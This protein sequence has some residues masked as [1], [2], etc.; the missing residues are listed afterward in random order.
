[1][2]GTGHQLLTTTTRTTVTV[3]FR[4]S[5]FT[6]YITLEEVT[7]AYFKCRKGKRNTLS[8]LK[9]EINYE[10]NNYQIYLDLNNKTY[11]ISPSIAFCTTKPL[12]REIFAANFRDRIVYTLFI[13][14]LIPTIEKHLIDNTFSCRKGKGPLCGIKQVS[15]M[16]KQAGEEA[17]YWKGDIQGF[18]MSIVPE[19]MWELVQEII[20]E[21]CPNNTDWWLWLGKIIIFNRPEQ[22]CIRAGDLKLWEKLPDR[23]SLFKSNGKGLPIGDLPS[24]V[25]SNLYLDGLDRF[26]QERLGKNEYYARGADDF[27]VIMQDKEKLLQLKND[28]K[29]WL[30]KNRKLI[31]HPKKNQ[32]QQV[33]RGVKFL[34][35]YIKGNR[36]YPSKRTI[37]GAKYIIK[38]FNSSKNKDLK[39][40]R[41]RLNSYFGLLRPYDSYNI[42]RKL[43]KLIKDY[44]H[45]LNINNKKIKII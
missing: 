32:I 39:R 38:E 25:L 23:K 41:N 17:W 18:F 42:R 19:I 40:F 3:L 15:K 28:V 22:N 36:I 2:R 29:I 45:L 16:M 9:Y 24:S 5:H 12:L 30:L 35:A 31:L 37:Y 33:K 8:A 11:T 6:M 34:G 20:K 10:L 43:W 21:A 1:M 26:I 4:F 14:K 27:I 13:N 7:E 44:S